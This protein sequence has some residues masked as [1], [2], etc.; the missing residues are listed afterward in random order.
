MPLF[1]IFI[2]FNNHLHST[3]IT[4]FILHHSPRPVFIFLAKMS[5]SRLL[6]C[7]DR[8]QDSCDFGIGCQTLYQLGYISSQSVRSHPARLDLIPLGQISSPS[9]RSHPTRLDLIHTWLDLS[10][11][12]LNIIPSR[13]DLI[14]DSARSRPKPKQISS[15]S[16]RSHSTLLDLIPTRQISSQLG[17]ISSETPQDLIPKSNAWRYYLSFASQAFF[18]SAGS[19]FSCFN[20]ILPS[21]S[22]LFGLCGAGEQARVR[23]AGGLHC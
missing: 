19:K 20:F 14:P 2:I 18:L 5:M 1:L 4:S 22:D 15:H 9:V 6:G 23:E 10:H 12:R 16:A 21:T 7:W 3:I 13:L 11:T 17:Q 8:T